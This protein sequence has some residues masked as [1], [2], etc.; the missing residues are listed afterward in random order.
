[1]LWAVLDNAVKYSPDGSPITVR[2][3]PETADR[4]EIVVTDEGAGMDATSSAHAFDQFYR[5]PDAA[6]LAADGSGI[7][8][9]AARGLVEA[10]GGSISLT[11]RLGVGTTVT[12]VLPAEQAERDDGEAVDR[13]SV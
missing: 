6:R 4:L 3:R 13:A 9:Y 1:V 5:A 11:S 2:I 10:M 8:L 12:C 7:G